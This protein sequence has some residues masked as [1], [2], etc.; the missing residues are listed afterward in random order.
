MGTAMVLIVP[1]LESVGIP[2]QE[3]AL[4]VTL[5]SSLSVIGRLGFG[6]LG[7]RMPKRYLLAASYGLVAVGALLIAFV[8]QF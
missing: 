5:L 2:R 8:T 3:A 1:Y 7:G 4:G 6:W